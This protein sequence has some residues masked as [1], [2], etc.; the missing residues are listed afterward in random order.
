MGSRTSF[1]AL[2]ALAL[3]APAAPAGGPPDLSRADRSIGKEPAY[4]ARQPLY[5]LAVFGPAAEKRVWMVLD[6]SRPDSPY[7][8]LHIDLDAD[9]D[10]TGPGERLT[11]EGG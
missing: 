3:A 10:L 6:R 7:D 4:V 5:G 8:V 2:A 1:W 9:G 11:S